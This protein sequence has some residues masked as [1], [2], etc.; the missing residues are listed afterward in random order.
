[1]RDHGLRS[2]VDLVA[3]DLTPTAG[4]LR[5]ALRVTL[6]TLVTLVVVMTFR[7][8][9]AVIA[10]YF[11]LVISRDNPMQSLRWTGMIAASI[12]ISLALVCGVMT[13][14]ENDPVIRLG[15]VP[16]VTFIAAILVYA[17]KN[18][19]VGSIGGY[20]YCIFISYWEDNT[21]P[22]LVLNRSALT[23]LALIF[24][25]LISTIV[26]F[27]FRYRKPQQVLVQQESERLQAVLA[28]YDGF[29]SYQPKAELLRRMQRCELLAVGGQME[30]QRLLHNVARQHGNRTGEGAPFSAVYIAMLSE[31]LDLTTAFGKRHI[32]NVSLSLVAI[33][34]SIEAACTQLIRGESSEIERREHNH[35]DVGQIEFL[36]RQMHLE[37]F[38]QR[39][40][41]GTYLVLEARDPSPFLPSGVWR[42]KAALGFACKVSLCATFCYVLYHA[43]AW[44]EI[45]SCVTTVL[46]TALSTTGAM[47]QRLFFR[48]AGVV[49]GG[50]VLGMG[51]IVFLFPNTDSITSLM[52][53]VSGVA[54]AAAWIGSGR[55]L[56]YLGLQ[57]GFCFYTVVFRGP[58][59]ETQVQSARDALVGI[60]VATA[61]MWLVFDQIW[62][63]RTVVAIRLRLLNLVKLVVGSLELAKTSEWDRKLL[64][65][66]RVVRYRSGQDL[67][68]IRTLNE[69]TRFDFSASREDLLRQANA[70]QGLALEVAA[71]GWDGLSFTYAQAQQD[72][73]SDEVR[74]FAN[75][76]LPVLLNLQGILQQTVWAVA[77]RS[78]RLD[79][80]QQEKRN[81]ERAAEALADL[82]VT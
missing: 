76:H 65:S 51:T 47:K 77:F 28:V 31:L 32:G 78:G 8:P 58:A 48:C 52:I 67:A 10:L 37:R 56:S 79:E 9:A 62:P 18:P 26:E 19:A 4:R 82:R 21:D 14:S 45:S 25:L 12:C 44:P 15:S 71:I 39:N 50:L 7:L 35:S 46:I 30:M 59:P 17:A 13:L 20:L 29:A 5:Q 80:R 54:F 81:A 38:V 36:L 41:N 43:V 68:K 66:M 1:M 74:Q 55:T 27:L 16:V 11:V 60:A 69:M 75:A 72:R 2:L 73:G 49:I 63:V 33:C 23:I 53:L 70:L 64:D 42:D 57:F 3:K 40:N 6:A 34:Q 24:A 22:A 61:V